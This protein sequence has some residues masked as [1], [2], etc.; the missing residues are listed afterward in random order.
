VADLGPRLTLK[1]SN[2]YFRMKLMAEF[3]YTR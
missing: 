2:L 3:L 1:V